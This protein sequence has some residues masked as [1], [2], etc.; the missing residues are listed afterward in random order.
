MIE[1]IQVIIIFLVL[2]W[3]LGLAFEEKTREIGY[4]LFLILGFSLY[5]IF[6]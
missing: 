3:A 1:V 4:A 5:L 6:I 2:C